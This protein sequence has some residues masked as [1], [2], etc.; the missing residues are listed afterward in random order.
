MATKRYPDAQ[1]SKKG[2]TIETGNWFQDFARDILEK[3]WGISPK[4][5]HSSEYQLV[6][7]EGRYCEFKHDP[8]S[9]YGHLSI[10]VAERAQ[11]SGG[12]AAAGIFRATEPYYVQGD[13]NE[14]FVIPTHML[15]RYANSIGI[16]WDYDNFL[17]FDEEGYVKTYNE[18]MKRFYLEYDVAV[19]IGGIKITSE[20][21]SA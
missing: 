6:R 18:T 15:I 8:H 5:Y 12:W 3:H 20:E 16:S 2:T 7:G 13:K 21:T 10:E 14:I 19:S 4:S 9:K 1:E 11:R 17:L